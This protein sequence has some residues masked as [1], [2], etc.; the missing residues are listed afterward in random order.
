MFVSFLSGMV[1][2]GGG[3]PGEKGMGNQPHY[4]QT[5]IYIYLDNAMVWQPEV[6]G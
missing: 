4:P 5:V 2:R 6:D 1:P 3:F